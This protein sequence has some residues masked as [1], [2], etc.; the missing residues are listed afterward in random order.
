MSL[1]SIEARIAKIAPLLETGAIEEALHLALI[2]ATIDAPELIAW[3]KRD[4]PP[5]VRID[6]YALPYETLTRL[7][8][9]SGRVFEEASAHERHVGA[10]LEYSCLPAC[11]F[12]RRRREEDS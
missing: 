9:E 10:P 1:E 8:H 2:V 6:F 12:C 7:A 11:E 5:D 3:I 4:P